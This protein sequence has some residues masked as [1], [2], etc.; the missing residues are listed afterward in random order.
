M[1]KSL[2]DRKLLKFLLVGVI[3]TLIGLAMNFVLFCLAGLSYRVSTSVS[4]ATGTVVSFFLNR[5]FTFGYNKRDLLAPLARFAVA[6]AI[7]YVIAY[8]AA[9][10][11]VGLGIGALKLSGVA[12]YADHI[13]ILL[14]MCLF[15]AM[16]YVS[17][18]L[19]VFA[20]AKKEGL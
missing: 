7:C 18:R 3:N 1:L 13:A 16:N 14:G 9:Q 2:F 11:L 8:K 12:P 15:T 10:P 4:T 6:Q 20:N 17:Q 19:F 5:R